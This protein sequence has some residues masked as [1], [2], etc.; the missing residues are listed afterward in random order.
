MTGSTIEISELGAAPH[1]EE[2]ANL[3]ERADRVATVAAEFAN[4]VDRDARFPEEAFGAAQAQ[5]IMSVLVPLELG[6]EGGQLRDATAICY[7]LG[8]ACAS[9]AMIFAM[10]QCC[11]SCLVR[12]GQESE[13]H[14]GLLRR[15]ASDQLLLASSTTEG[16]SGGNLRSSSSPIE[17]VGAA[18]R[19]DRAATVVSYGARADGIVTTARRSPEAAAND[20]IL[21]AF[22]RSDYTLSPLSSWDALGM[23]GTCSAGFALRA[24][25][26]P[27]QILPEPYQSI[28]AQTMV[29]IHHLV[30]ASVWAGIAAGA[31]ERARAYVRQAARSSN[32]AMPP[33]AAQLTLA[34]ASL[35]KL[36]GLIT[37][38]LRAFEARAEDPRALRSLEFQVTINL[39]KVEAS[40][41]ALQTVLQAMRACGLSG[42]RNDS[43]FSLCRALRDILSAPIM[44]NNDRIL[45]NIASATL[46]SALPSGLED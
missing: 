28:H 23:R 44:I 37:S 31:T 46:M 15:I 34:Q 30:W 2:Y 18:I 29:P 35:T 10:H 5:R 21:V 14:R 26:Q 20:Q 6:G 25:G 11:V 42:Y 22:C 33:A 32:G 16:Q 3:A 19:L 40:E 45:G 4:E 39:T 9:T 7:R 1:Q 17:E 8:R 12:H 27:A 38:S 13:W 36:R 41:L 43:E 24:T